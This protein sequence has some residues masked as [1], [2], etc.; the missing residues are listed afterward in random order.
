MNV[1]IVIPVLNERECLPLAVKSVRQ[2]LPQAQIIVADGGSIDGSREWTL[3]QPDIEFI[4]A[5]RGKGLQQNAGAARAVGDAL[6]FLHADCQLPPDAAVELECALTDKKTAGGCFFVRFV[7]RR[8][9]SLHVLSFAMNLRAKILRRCFGDQALFVR[10]NVFDQFGG[11]PNWPLFE[12]Y[13][14][15]RRMKR[16]GSFAVITSAI[17]LSARRFLAHGV[18]RTVMRVFLLQA[19]FYL[20]LS[21]A[22]L[23]RWFIDIRPHLGQTGTAD[24]NLTFDECEGDADATIA[25]DRRRGTGT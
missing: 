9:A 20:G 16:Y 8:P 21:P 2:A 7:E 4:G 13:E 1:S 23:K 22:R 12:D 17:T 15:V 10:R 19:A 14:F 5:V 25:I 11:F 18:W 6:L 24:S 3:A